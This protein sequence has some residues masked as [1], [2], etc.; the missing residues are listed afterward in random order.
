MLSNGAA[1]ATRE[2]APIS[3]IRSRSSPGFGML[4]APP[5]ALSRRFAL[6]LLVRSPAFCLAAV[7]SLALGIGANSAIFTVVHAVLLRPLPYPQAGRL[8]EQ[9]N[10][11]LRSDQTGA[12]AAARI[13]ARS[14]A[15][16]VKTTVQGFRPVIWAGRLAAAGSSRSSKPHSAQKLA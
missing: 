2:V 8:K 13:L 5:P 1:R 9:G 10:L 7:G 6:R 14:Q 16:I 15:T 12:P 4:P 3:S 11:V